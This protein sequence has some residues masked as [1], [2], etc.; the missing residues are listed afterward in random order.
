M[1]E[2]RE[3]LS[4]RDLDT[5]GKKDA[6]IERLEQAVARERSDGSEKIAPGDTPIGQKLQSSDT[7]ANSHQP[8]GSAEDGTAAKEPL[9]AERIEERAKRFGV[10]PTAKRGRQ[11]QQDGEQRKSERE[12]RFGTG[13][14]EEE[15]KRQ[16]EREERFRA[17]AQTHGS[18]ANCT[19]GVDKSD[20]ASVPGL[21][22]SLELEQRKKQRVERFG[23]EDAE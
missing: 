13:L 10:E 6:L 19:G 15:K 21:G 20:L 4:S 12:Q 16:R 14:S 1:Q 9:D 7:Q 18:S 5:S 2:L 8:T 11:D 17:S 22:D 23:G 3:A